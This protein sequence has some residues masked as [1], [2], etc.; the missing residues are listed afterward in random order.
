MV[1]SSEDDGTDDWKPTQDSSE[2]Y[3]EMEEDP[4]RQRVTE[5]VKKKRALGPIPQRQ[6]S[7]QIQCFN[8]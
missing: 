7:N 1:R 2:D 3:S 6:V 5:V 4:V 8:T